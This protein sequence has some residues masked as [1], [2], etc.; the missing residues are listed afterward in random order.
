MPPAGGSFCVLKSEPLNASHQP[1]LL[2]ARI[3]RGISKHTE[4]GQAK[5][6]P[7]PGH[8][9]HSHNRTVV[10]RLFELLCYVA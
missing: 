5:G 4:A 3:I 8:C 6:G 10:E 9:L 7:W 2:P 1:D